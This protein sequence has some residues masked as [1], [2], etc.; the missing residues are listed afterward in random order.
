MDWIKLAAIIVCFFFCIRLGQRCSSR[1][2]LNSK[3]DTCA[4]T[5]DLVQVLA[6]PHLRF[7]AGV[8]STGF[9]NLGRRRSLG[10]INNKLQSAIKK[11]PQIIPGRTQDKHRMN[12]GCTVDTLYLTQLDRTLPKPPGH[13][14]ERRNHTEVEVLQCADMVTIPQG[15]LANHAA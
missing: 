1:M 3:A 4:S 7:G 15:Y 12:T 11:P 5:I 13:L 6:T 14:P 9:A 8:R 10:G 2:H